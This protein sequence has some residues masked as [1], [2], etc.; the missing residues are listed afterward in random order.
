MALLVLGGLTIIGLISSVAALWRS[1]RSL[2]FSR[3]YLNH[4]R[5]LLNSQTQGPPR[6]LSSHYTLFDEDEHEWL[7]KRMGRMQ[8]ELGPANR[9]VNYRPAYSNFVYSSYELLGNTL[10][11][12]KISDAHPHELLWCDDVILAHLGELEEE[13]R[14]AAL[15]LINPLA[16]LVRGVRT[17]VTLPLNLAYLSGL[18]EYGEYSRAAGSKI[19]GFLAFV[20]TA[21]ASIV[22]IVLGWEQFTEIVRGLLGG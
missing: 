18:M 14:A 5:A 11:K 8:R 9:L 1:N 7:V 15:R 17:I 10:R 4:F 13:R 12:V 3:D 22:T 21:G 19:T 20:L 16:W 6:G 2:D